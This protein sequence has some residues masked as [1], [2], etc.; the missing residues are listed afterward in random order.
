MMEKVREV[1]MTMSDNSEFSE[2]LRENLDALEKLLLEKNH[3]YGPNNLVTFG[4]LGILIR[5]M[6][7]ME[8][9][10]NHVLNHSILTTESLDDTL[11][12]IA[13]YA[14][15]WLVLEEEGYDLDFRTLIEQ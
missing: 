2:I 14:I 4:N 7:K 1:K 6:D 13:G 3:D 9:L 8:R 12:D 10:K 15:M 5:L 11:R